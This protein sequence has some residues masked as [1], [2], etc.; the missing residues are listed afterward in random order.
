ML[1][2]VMTAFL[3]ASLQCTSALVQPCYLTTK[4]L[5]LRVHVQPFVMVC[6]QDTM[7][8]LNAPN[9]DILLA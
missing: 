4:L 5:E 3:M 1:V 6:V 8:M 2:D 7:R 9:K